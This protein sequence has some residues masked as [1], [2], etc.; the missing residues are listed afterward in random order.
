MLYIFEISINSPFRQFRIC[1]RQ[2]TFNLNATANFPVAP[3]AH[4]MHHNERGHFRM[5][6]ASLERS[7]SQG[8]FCQSLLNREIQDHVC[9][10]SLNNR[11]CKVMH[12]EKGALRVADVCRSQLLFT[13]R[14]CSLSTF[15]TNIYYSLLIS[16]KGRAGCPCQDDGLAA[17]YNQ[18]QAHKSTWGLQP[19]RNNEPRDVLFPHTIPCDPYLAH[20][21]VNDGSS[22]P[23]CATATATDNAG[24]GKD[25]KWLPHAQPWTC[26]PSRDR[27]YGPENGSHRPANTS[28]PCSHVVSSKWNA[29]WL[30]FNNSCPLCRWESFPSMS[31]SFHNVWRERREFQVKGGETSPF[32]P[33]KISKE[34][35]HGPS[36]SHWGLQ[37]L[38]WL[39]IHFTLGCSW[40][41]VFSTRSELLQSGKIRHLYHPRPLK[42][43]S[44]QSPRVFL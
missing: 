11:K 30:K 3:F 22:H 12:G 40:E 19:L 4:R 17:Y 43:N 9:L 27:N 44:R 2:V 13:T 38:D 23:A 18:N 42:R 14:K 36:A 21:E 8:S 6:I 29:V 32:K 39:H 15:T 34:K 31:D 26:Q 10:F 16:G 28:M 41:D 35:P 33:S 20:L 7:V 5:C 25:A 24:M 1:A 37:H